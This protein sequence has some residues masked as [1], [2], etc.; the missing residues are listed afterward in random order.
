MFR[1]NILCFQGPCFVVCPANP[2]MI[3]EHSVIL[4]RVCIPL[5]ECCFRSGANTSYDLGG[6]VLKS[7][8]TVFY[9]VA[10]QCVSH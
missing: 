2:Y 4:K 10:V 3:L 7:K 1:L 6:L 9:S 8:S 5:S